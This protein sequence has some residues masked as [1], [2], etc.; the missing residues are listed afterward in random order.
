M[1][2]LNGKTFMHEK[3]KK[4]LGNMFRIF[5]RIS[6]T[7]PADVVINRR[8]EDTFLY[9][10]QWVKTK[11]GGWLS[12]RGLLVSSAVESVFQQDS[13][14]HTNIPYSQ[15][16]LSSNLTCTKLDLHRT[17]GT[18]RLRKSGSGCM[19][20]LILRSEVLMAANISFTAFCYA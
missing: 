20:L 6:S 13:T 16:N 4:M 15:P 9:C 12:C 17:Y 2:L 11:N 18:W 5:H 8:Q 14:I 10:I 1:T 7:V 3:E 19:D